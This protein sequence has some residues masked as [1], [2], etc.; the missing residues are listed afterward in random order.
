MARLAL[1]SLHDEFCLGLRHL[2]GYLARAGHEIVLIHF[3]RYAGYEKDPTGRSDCSDEADARGAREAMIQVLASGEVRLAFASS[4]TQEERDALLQVL[5][6]KKPNVAGISVPSYYRETARALT[7]DIRTRLA[8]PVVWGGVHPTVAPEDCLAGDGA[9]DAICLGEGEESFTDYV[10]ALESGKDFRTTPVAG[11]WIR[12]DGDAVRNEKRPVQKDL[13]RYAWQFH[14]DGEF[15]IEGARVRRRADLTD[16]SLIWTYKALTSRGC[17]ADCA[18]CINSILKRDYADA[19]RVRLRSPGD[20]I[21][22]LRRAKETMPYLHSIEFYDEVFVMRRAWIAEFAELYKKEIALPFWCYTFP[23]MASRENLETL[24]D[25]GVAYVSMG[26][27]SGSDRVNYEV[28][29]RRTSRESILK[30]ASLIADAGIPACYDLI[31]NNPYETEEDR[32]ETLDLIARLPG[33]YSLQ[34][35][36]LAFL[37]GTPLTTRAEAEGKIGTADPKTYRF[38]NALYLLAAHRVADRET[39]LGLSRDEHLR[40]NPQFLWDALRHGVLAQSEREEM[41]R[42]KEKVRRQEEDVES[43]RSRHQALVSRRAVRLA[44]R[45]ADALRRTLG[46]D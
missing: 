27:Q 21:A 15:V 23:T 13:D 2:G 10:A 25:M 1:I 46:R 26:I 6:E 33:E 14:D 30:A 5:S 44:V 16:S 12:T 18:F 31:T 8:I 11:M 42:L 3:Q 40:R 22:E 17:P 7:R 20:V 19:K 34:I 39:L 9:P 37:P 35:S 29:N 41:E 36:H 43:L 38:W 32:R 28:F 24:K 4:S 45:L